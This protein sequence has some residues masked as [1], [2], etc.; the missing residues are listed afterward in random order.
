[1]VN[2]LQKFNFYENELLDQKLLYKLL[3]YGK[4]VCGFYGL[5]KSAVAEEEEKGLCSGQKRKLCRPP[6]SNPSHQMARAIIN[7]MTF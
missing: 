7:G 1:M 6:L 2:N 4:S 3:W 5:K